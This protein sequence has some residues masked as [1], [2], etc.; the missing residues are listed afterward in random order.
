MKKFSVRLIRKSINFDEINV[1]NVECSAKNLFWFCI[2]FLFGVCSVVVI[3]LLAKEMLQ[4]VQDIF[5][6]VF[7]SLIFVV[8]FIY[9]LLKIKNCYFSIKNNK[10]LYKNIL[11][12]TYESEIKEIKDIK[13]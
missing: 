6:F 1:D 4:T 12:I 10:M 9:C 13:E 7:I 5:A 8:P 11:G 2:I 3:V